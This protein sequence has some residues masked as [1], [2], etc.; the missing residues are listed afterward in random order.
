MVLVNC[1]NMA[2]QIAARMIMLKKGAGVQWRHL[3]YSDLPT[4]GKL[5]PCHEFPLSSLVS[6]DLARYLLCQLESLSCQCHCLSQ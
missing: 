6:V 2:C 3:V 5:H 4:I 1:L